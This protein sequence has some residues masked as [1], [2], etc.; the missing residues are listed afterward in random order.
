[1]YPTKSDCFL[2]HFL[3][4]P[5]YLETRGKV[6]FSC[7]CFFVSLAIG[8]GFCEFVFSKYSLTLSAIA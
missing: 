7:L 3:C 2:L 5:T 8:F 6:Y 4:I 1:M